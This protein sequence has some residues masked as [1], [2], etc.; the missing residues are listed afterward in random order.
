MTERSHAAAMSNAATVG[1][2]RV[3]DPA[4]FILSSKAALRRRDRQR[5]IE[6]AVAANGGRYPWSRRRGDT[7]PGAA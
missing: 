4:V 6:R 3:D 1:R 5:F 2:L 7:A